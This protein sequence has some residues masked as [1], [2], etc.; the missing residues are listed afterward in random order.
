MVNLPPQGGFYC[1]GDL[2]R[3]PAG[4]DT[5]MG[6]FRAALA[7]KVIVVPGEFF[8]NAKVDRTQLF[9]SQILAH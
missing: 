4:L 5:G 8:D 7:E 3:L 2:R 1:W 6:L 9:L